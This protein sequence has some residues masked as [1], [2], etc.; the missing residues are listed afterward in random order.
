MP[1][2]PAL[3]ARPAAVLLAATALVLSATTTATAADRF[4]LRE[5][6]Q[7]PGVRAVAVEFYATWCKP[8]MRAVPRWKAL[9]ERYR[10]EGLRLVVINTQDPEGRCV[11]PGW[12]P[13]Q[14][15]C[16]EEGDLA[17]AWGVGQ[18]LPA[19]FVWSW[20]GN[21]LV[22][23][24]HV[25]HAERALRRYLRE[26]PRVAVQADGGEAQAAVPRLR[27]R[28]T[29]TGKLV[30]VAGKE[31]RQALARMRKRSHDLRYDQARVCEVGLEV[32]ANALLKVSVTGRKSR[33]R[34]GVTLYS[35]VSACALAA[36][37]VPWDLAR[38]GTSV[39]EA[40]DKIL[41]KLRGPLQMPGGPA[42]TRPPVVES[43]RRDTSAADWN[44]ADDE[45]VMVSF[46]SDPPD[47]MVMVDNK[48]I[49][50][51]PCNKALSP[52]NHR[53]AM[54]KPQYVSRDESAR[55]GAGQTVSWTLQPDFALL[56]VTTDPAGVAVTVDGK[57]VTAGEAQRLAPGGHN[58]VAED[59]CHAAHRKT[60][61]LRRGEKR[62]E[63]LRPVVR[64]AG[65]M[66]LVADGRGSDVKGAEVWIDGRRLGP[67]FKALKVPLC[68]KEAEV[69][70]RELGEARVGLSL[71]ERKTSRVEVR[72]GS[73][74]SGR[75]GGASALPS[76]G[77][78]EEGV[79]YVMGR[80][81]L[82]REPGSNEVNL[83]YDNGRYA[84]ELIADSNGWWRWRGH[85]NE[86]KVEPWGPLTPVRGKGREFYERPWERPSK[87]PA[88]QVSPG[89][90]FEVRGKHGL[91][92]I[93]FEEGEIRIK[94][95]QSYPNS[96]TIPVSGPTVYHSG[97]RGESHEYR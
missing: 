97:S 65:L 20:Q 46:A 14:M 61:H 49:C 53:V 89:S 39:A 56:T 77:L 38:P 30:V 87:T 72:L 5:W 43:E 47:A 4:D 37:S 52:G 25:E 67:A 54:H 68:A 7:R 60:V 44:P 28:L 88:R 55:L 26:L 15:I 73:G 48:P 91:A 16:D 58:L 22:R 78:G 32:P 51:T 64:P 27:E 71:V 59:G 50:Q 96:I 62:T 17:R 34:L 31:E 86:H 90:G 1:G 81:S 18:R 66:V 24:G 9:H 40:V 42:V 85:G 41:G 75:G 84:I 79:L 36:T 57:A 94:L 23:K 45:L 2:Q 8:C 80:W 10:R 92:E 74:D 70:H 13:D 76:G 63:V 93:R 29:E 12:N 69:R 21:L 19:A 95:S 33:R 3:A 11:N 82:H 35:A 83:W 6:L